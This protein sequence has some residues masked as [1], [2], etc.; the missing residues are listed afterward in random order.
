MFN[1]VRHV[2]ELFVSQTARR[3][4]SRSRSQFELLEPRL[5][6]TAQAV[7]VHSDAAKAANFA[8]HWTTLAPPGNYSGPV[9]IVQTGNHATVT[10][11]AI[12]VAPLPQFTIDMTVHGKNM[13]SDFSV[14]DTSS[15]WSYTYTGHISFHLDS[16]HKFHGIV[17]YSING[18][19][20]S[21]GNINFTASKA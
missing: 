17:Y 10:V 6:L 1:I 11:G 2:V 15:G 7:G 20:A 19:G 9:D 5:L 18:G 13:A 3:R 8:G 4:T 16:P 12:A 14:V 21:S